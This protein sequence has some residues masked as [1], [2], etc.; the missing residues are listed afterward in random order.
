[1]RG[2]LAV[3]CAGLLSGCAAEWPSFH[4]AGDSTEHVRLADVPFYPQ[5]G[6]RCG[7][8]AMAMVLSWSGLDIK[9]AALETRFAQTSDPRRALMD[10]ASHYGRLAY[11][12]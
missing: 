11:P 9:P 12:L 5:E 2:L 4:G 3:L 7:S 10:S 6:H 8:A 1:M